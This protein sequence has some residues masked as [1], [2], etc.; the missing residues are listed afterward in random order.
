MI[1]KGLEYANIVK[2]SEEEMEFITGKVDLEEGTRQLVERYNT[3][4]IIVTLGA[5][6]C[7]YRKG[8]ST[9]KFNS[10]KVNP[11]DTTGAGDGF[12]SGVIYKYLE[13]NKPITDLSIKDMEEII[14]FANAVGAIVTTRKGA[15]LSMPCMKEVKKL[16]KNQNL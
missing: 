8:E 10:F 11:V 9:R 14:I 6:G 13:K 4:L 7:F 2:L 15:I 5:E 3:E 12:F 1:K 16:L